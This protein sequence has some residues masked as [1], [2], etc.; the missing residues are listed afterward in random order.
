MASRGSVSASAKLMHNL[1][2]FCIWQDLMRFSGSDLLPKLT[3]HDNLVSVCRTGHVATKT[4][5]STI[6]FLML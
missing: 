5:N 3:S 2:A 4:I 6:A 1:S